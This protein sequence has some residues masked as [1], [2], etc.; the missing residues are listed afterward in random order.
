[1]VKQEKKKVEKTISEPVYLKYVLYVLLALFVYVWI[2]NAWVGDDAYI[3]F[4]TVDNFVNGYGLTWNTSERVQAYTHPLW[5]FIHSF[6]YAITG[7]IYYTT[8]FLSFAFSFAAVWLLVFKIANN[9]LLAI[10]GLITLLISKTFIDYTSSGL[11]NPLTYFLIAL[12]LIFYFKDDEIK[13][14]LFKLSLLTALVMLNRMD[15]VLLFLPALIYL[16][17][18]N[19]KARHLL[20]MFYGFIP[21]LVW[22]IFSVIYYGFPFPNTYYAKLNTGIPIGEYISQGL[23][24]YANL[25]NNDPMSGIMIFSGIIGIIVYS[26]KKK[27]LNLY[28]PLVLGIILYL[29]Y[30][31]RIGG[32]FMS[33][34]F[35]TSSFLMVV[36]ILTSIHFNYR[37][38]ELKFVVP[39]ILIALIT[40]SGFTSDHPV[41]TYSGH[42]SK[43]GKPYTPQEAEKF[44]RD[45]NHINDERGIFYPYSAVAKHF[46]SGITVPTFVT[47]E[48][49]KM[50]RQSNHKIISHYMI[51]RLGFYAGPKIHIIDYLALA[52]PFLSKIKANK[53]PDWK[54]NW[55][56][57]HFY[58]RIPIG[59]VETIKSGMN[60]LENMQ[61]KEYFEK[62]K[63]VTQS[64]IFS[65]ERFSEIWKL[66]TGYYDDLLVSH[67]KENDE[68]KLYSG[69]KYS[70]WVYYWRLGHYYS[71][72]GK[73]NQAIDS[74]MKL[75]IDREFL[76][77]SNNS[78]DVLY[79]IGYTYN[80][81]NKSD[82]AL[83][84]AKKSFEIETRI[85]GK[86]AVLHLL[87]QVHNN[88][89]FRR[90]ALDALKGIIKLDSNSVFGLNNCAKY[91]YDEGK[92]KEA[93]ELWHRLI[94]IYP[95]N[96]DIYFNLYAV[97]INKKNYDSA[98]YYAFKTVELGGKIDH[99]ALEILRKFRH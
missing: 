24:Y 51:G 69:D 53:N 75:A 41:L 92:E 86:L 37:K 6:F 5:M 90:N 57:G 38:K 77:E 96:A 23:S 76:F 85:K 73:L 39:A 65:L 9:K 70:L 17:A 97:Y 32:D 79:N 74:W 64:G 47:V 40:I 49:G 98:A 7:N 28:L 71:Q 88:L 19:W 78:A 81:L 1:M 14:K 12:F 30:I 26:V 72:K 67:Y 54:G 59:Y 36:A 42:G 35:F 44:F 15:L 20:Y 3:T 55:R 58:R 8:M 27:N 21:F 93:L 13:N 11:E 31:L 33:G 61:L 45:M 56:I 50:T 84:Y 63:I 89:G 87:F 43:N 46:F 22:E 48:Q 94:K 99:K 16:I 82:S 29:L 34:R 2:V 91:Y 52:E 18:K 4:R 83:N 95:Q 62:L 60:Q 68:P 66:N 25:F 80:L 10:A